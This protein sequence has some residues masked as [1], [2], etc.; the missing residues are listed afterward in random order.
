MANSD[1]LLFG[2]TVLIH[3]PGIPPESVRWGDGD[4]ASLKPLRKLDDGSLRSGLVNLPADWKIPSAHRL[5]A[6][7]QFLVRNGRVGLGDQVLEANAFVVVP[8]GGV[9]P[10][11]RAEADSQLLVIN[12]AGQTWTPAAD[13]NDARVTANVFDIEPIVPVIHGRPLTGFE[14]R[15]LWLDPDTGADTR[16]LRIPADFN[17]PGASWHPVNEEIF[18]LDGEIAPARGQMMTP[19]SF[20]WNP[21]RCVHG[22]YEHTENGCVLL[23]WH[24]GPWD[25]IRYDEAGT[26]KD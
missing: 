8:A 6:C 16:L 10:P 11:L 12:D 21:E 7:F 3:E 13:G 17:G 23:E 4:S 15:V 14:R 24:D 9:I 20:L 2:T 18:C 5:S 25:I 19:G 1:E 26:G 22:Y